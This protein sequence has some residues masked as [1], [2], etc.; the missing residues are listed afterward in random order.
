[1]QEVY[2]TGV[3]CHGQYNLLYSCRPDDK[4]TLK[5]TIGKGKMPTRRFCAI[6][7]AIRELCCRLAT[8]LDSA[9]FL[10]MHRN[11]SQNGHQNAFTM[12]LSVA[13]VSLLVT[14]SP[15]ELTQLSSG[16]WS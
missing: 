7:V 10:P 4:S 16:Y 5:G 14:F 3:N 8:I 13:V 6:L 2:S 11:R 1:M 12:S 15:R 9:E